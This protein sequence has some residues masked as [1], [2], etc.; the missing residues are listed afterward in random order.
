[1]SVLDDAGTPF[2]QRVPLQAE[3]LEG[4]SPWRRHCNPVGLRQTGS[5]ERMCFG[6]L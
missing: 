1:M 2:L 6:A 4:A 3:P 5:I